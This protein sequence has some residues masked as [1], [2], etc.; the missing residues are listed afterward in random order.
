MR[1][2][3]GRTAHEENTVK[4]VDIG[5]ML[6]HWRRRRV[7]E[8]LW[9]HPD[10][11]RWVELLRHALL[12][13]YGM[14]PKEACILSHAPDYTDPQD[15]ATQASAFCPGPW[16]HVGLVPRAQ[17]ERARAEWIEADNAL[18]PDYGDD[19][20]D[21]DSS[22][23]EP[24]PSSSQSENDDRAATAATAPDDGDAPETTQQKHAQE[25]A[26]SA[27]AINAATWTAQGSHMIIAYHDGGYTPLDAAGDKPAI[28]GWGYQLQY[29]PLADL[30]DGDDLPTP[31]IQDRR[32][33]SL[34]SLSDAS[35]PQASGSVPI[36]HSAC[37]ITRSRYSSG[38]VI[39]FFF[40]PSLH[41]GILEV[42]LNQ[43]GAHQSS[44]FSFH[45]IQRRRDLRWELKRSGTDLGH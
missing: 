34:R 40:R 28:A 29:I 23:S 6:H 19:D 12:V 39:L 10:D 8:V 38:K 16:A 25:A 9:S 14:L 3:T 45:L 4:S 17:A 11:P 43:R 44:S 42:P 22:E 13:Y 31:R 32:P 37:S 36:V 20:E 18:K 15:L 1:L 27:A 2:F 5:A 7:G 26:L 21:D 41:S 30:P 24:E 33:K 35:S